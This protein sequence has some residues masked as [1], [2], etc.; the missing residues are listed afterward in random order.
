MGQIRNAILIAIRGTIKDLTRIDDAIAIGIF[1]GRSFR[2]KN[3]INTID[4]TIKCKITRSTASTTAVTTTTTS[5]RT[6]TR[7]IGLI[8]LT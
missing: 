5:S 1:D 2:K 7:W 8:R 6:T 3:I 4:T